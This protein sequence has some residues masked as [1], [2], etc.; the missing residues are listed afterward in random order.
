MNHHS[1]DKIVKL[2]HCGR[3]DAARMAGCAAAYEW[4]R[5]GKSAA[6]KGAKLQGMSLRVLGSSEFRELQRG[7]CALS[8]ASA[9][10]NDSQIIVFISDYHSK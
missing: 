2:Q 5:G 8:V 3:K 6:P 10:N 1:H 9:Y 7:H 4:M